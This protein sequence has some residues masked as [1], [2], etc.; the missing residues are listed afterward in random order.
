MAGDAII[1]T[2]GV[3]LSAVQAARIAGAAQIIAADL[4]D[5]RLSLA[6]E[7][8]ATDTVRADAGDDMAALARL[9]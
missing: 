8:G 7:L 2:G 6:T 5:H 4:E 1:G 9:L 3:G